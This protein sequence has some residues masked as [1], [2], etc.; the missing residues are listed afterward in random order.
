[1]T[2]TKV[3]RWNLSGLG[4]SSSGYNGKYELA[5]TMDGRINANF[6]TT[7]VLN[8]SI[9]QTGALTSKDGSVNINLDNGSFRI[10]GNGAVAEHTPLGSK[11]LHWNGGYT[12]VTNGGLK[13]ET[14]QGRTAFSVDNSGYI[15]N[16]W[17]VKT[18]VKPGGTISVQGNMMADDQCSTLLRAFGLWHESIDGKYNMRIGSKSEIWFKNLADDWQDTRA[19]WMMANQFRTTY[20]NNTGVIL[21][22]NCVDSGTGRL[23][24]NWGGGTHGNIS[25]T[26]ICDGMSD[27]SYGEFHCGSLYTHGSKNRAVET[28]HFGTRALGAYETPTPYFGDISRDICEVIDGQCIV[29]IE[30]IFRETITSTGKYQ[31]FLSK[32]GPGDIWTEEMHPTYFIVKGANIKFSWELKAIQRGYENNRLEQV[33]I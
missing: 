9:V 12:Q 6:I 27:G 29:P 20:D 30:P 26:L 8:A 4:Y 16:E 24:L 11:Y 21:R 32:Y 23:Y 3:W 14:S 17:G 10:G 15:L 25:K 33:E 18:M 22:E 13:I 1:M 19:R 28:E 31:V 2:A 7:G 5:M